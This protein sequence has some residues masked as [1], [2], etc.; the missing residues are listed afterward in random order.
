MKFYLLLLVFL[1]SLNAFCDNETDTL[2]LCSRNTPKFT[3][4]FI[5]YLNDS[6]RDSLNQLFEQWKQSCGDCEP[7]QRA[8]IIY[9][10]KFNCYN[11]SILDKS[12]ACNIRIFR[13][14]KLLN[15]F[16]NESYFSYVPVWGQFDRYTD[17]V[18][19]STLSIYNRKS[20]E[21]L[22]S[23]FYGN[24]SDSLLIKIRNPRYTGSK[25]RYYRCKTNI[26]SRINPHES[27]QEGVNI[28]VMTGA[29]IPTGRLKVLGVHPELGFQ[30]GVTKQN[31]TAQFTL[32]IRFLKTPNYFMARRVKTTDSLERAN[33]FVGPY[34][35]LDFSRRI[36]G[37]K[38]IEMLFLGGFGFDAATVLEPSKKDKSYQDVRSYNI[39]FGMGYRVYLHN[40][41]YLGFEAKY[42]IV[43][44]TLNGAIDLKGNYISIRFI[45]GYF[46]KY[47]F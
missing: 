41:S 21:Y 33:T 36:V 15:Y 31:Y 27:L 6:N 47:K 38:N 16:N 32:M 12:I 42:N 22:L 1:I 37:D 19:K 45:Y 17:S 5:K 8:K 34:L 20:I 25:I 7:L 2:N 11:D 26:N 23:E 24:I 18:A 44:Y 10:L 40:H 14:R 30:G 9:S 28:G 39:N 29:W 13:E 4:N 46:E 3:A 43:D 35:G